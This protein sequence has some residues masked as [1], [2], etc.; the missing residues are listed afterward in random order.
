MSL[1]E[2][3]PLCMENGV[4]QYEKYALLTEKGLVI[5]KENLLTVLFISG[6]YHMS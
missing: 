2:D 6:L 3:H 5:T 1:I 4:F